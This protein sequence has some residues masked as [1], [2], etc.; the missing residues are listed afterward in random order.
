M[1]ALIMPYSY[2]EGHRARF[3][4][5]P[6]R[7]VAASSPRLLLG[8][9][10]HGGAASANDLGF[11]FVREVH[12]LAAVPYEATSWDLRGFSWW[13][14]EF[15]QR[16]WAEPGVDEGGSMVFKVCTA[17]DFVNDV[18]ADSPAFVDQVAAAARSASTS[19][20]VF[21]PRDRTLR[22][23]TTITLHEDIGSWVFP[24]MIG[25]AYSQL[26]TV[27]SASDAAEQVFGGKRDR[28]SRP[29]RGPSS[30]RHARIEGW[31][32]EC[33]EEGRNCSAWAGTTEF[34]EAIELLRSGNITASLTDQGLVA[35]FPF[36]TNCLADEAAV[37]DLPADRTGL[38]E[39]DTAEPHPTHRNGLSTRLHLPLAMPEDL[40]HRLCA[41]LNLLETREFT[42]SCLVG[43]W[44][45]DRDGL[46]F[47]SFI[48]NI[49]YVPDMVANL[50]LAAQA[51]TAWVAAKLGERD[52]Q[53]AAAEL[54]AAVLGGPAPSKRRAD[55]PAQPGP[56]QKPGLLRKLFRR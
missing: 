44:R 56:S 10:S 45:A 6:Q 15:R 14:G 13:V 28:N 48:P 37:G 23:W 5:A 9:R 22:H 2:I 38:F 53:D 32:A 52:R 36:A 4:C 27:N 3:N 19:A 49:L 20:L 34:A 8:E 51:R 50:A 54:I 16:I 24:L 18:D 1:L 17:T 12:K 11:N 26:A 41:A 47:A 43:S 7:G 39:M 30:I 29:P 46:V 42:R 25:S 40:T 31:Y 55:R 33:E 21:D 35:G